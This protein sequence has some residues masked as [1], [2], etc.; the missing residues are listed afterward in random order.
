MTPIEER[1]RDLLAKLKGC[2][3]PG[4]RGN[5]II[6]MADARVLVAALR[7][8]TASPA[9]DP[10]LALE[11]PE[12]LLSRAQAAE[13]SLAEARVALEMIA[14]HPGPHG[15]EG[16]FWRADEARSTLAKLGGNTSS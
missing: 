6:S 13:Q 15:D 7:V 1:R 3:D 11:D 4:R 5:I 12:S 8:S 9:S 10:S 16:A 2:D 14:E